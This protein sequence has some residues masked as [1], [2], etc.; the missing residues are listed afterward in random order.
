MGKLLDDLVNVIRAKGAKPLTK[1]DPARGALAQRYENLRKLMF[2]DDEGMNI[3]I[4][5][6][7]TNELRMEKR[8]ASMKGTLNPELMKVH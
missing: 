7:E 8:R 1:N 6:L 3:L 4:S 5:P 2:E